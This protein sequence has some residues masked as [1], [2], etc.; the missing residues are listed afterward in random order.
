MRATTGKRVKWKK[1][2]LFVTH[3]LKKMHKQQQCSN[4][5]KYQRSLC[6]SVPGFLGQMQLQ[7][8]NSNRCL[9]SF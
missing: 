6:F 7:V 3:S 1:A 8:K 5:I 9:A 4:E 2:L